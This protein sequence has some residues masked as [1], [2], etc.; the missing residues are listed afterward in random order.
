[1][2]ILRSS[3]GLLAQKY[4]VLR[5]AFVFPASSDRPLQVVMRERAVEVVEVDAACDD[6]EALKAADI[7]R[8]FDLAK[9]SLLRLTVAHLGDDHHAMIWSAHH[10]VIDGWCLSLLFRDFAEY[11]RRL[12]AGEGEE[13]IGAALSSE[14]VLPFGDYVEWLERQ[15]KRQAYEYWDGVL[16]GYSDAI[17]IP[18]AERR[19]KAE[20]RPC[21][22]SRSASPE[23]TR[24][25]EALAAKLHVTTS[26][27]VETVWALLLQK[28]NGTDDV[29]F[30]KVVSGRGA[31]LAGIEQAVGLFDLYRFFG[32]GIARFRIRN[33]VT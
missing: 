30:G 14:P 22:E 12:S 20:A 33:L 3:V 8:G 5:S 27:V 31:P 25:L 6:Y 11:Y 29:V 19:R 4:E 1:M 32:H 13:E 7:E 15:D 10:I 9:D 24:G 21:R 26:T 2:G 18:P 17:T 23:L 28:Y 16:E